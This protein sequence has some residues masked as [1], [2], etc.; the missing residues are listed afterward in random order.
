MLG[1]VYVQLKTDGAAKHLVE[2]RD[3]D[4][5]SGADF[6]YIDI[7]IYIIQTYRHRLR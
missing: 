3:G 7:G 1:I 6:R 4:I 5:S 2:G